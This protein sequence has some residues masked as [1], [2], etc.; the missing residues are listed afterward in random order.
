M[1]PLLEGDRLIGRIDMKAER[2]RDS[3]AVSGLWTEPG[4]ALSKARRQR[5]DAELERMR[6]WAGL[7][8]VRWNNGAIR[9]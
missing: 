1:F 6:R 9:A 5:L 7:A 2:G 4:I 8:T 3:L